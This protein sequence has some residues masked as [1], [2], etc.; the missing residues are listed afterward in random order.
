MK[1]LVDIRD[2]KA[3]FVMELLNNF[4]FVKTKPISNE[5]ALLM[6]EIKEAVENVKRAKQGKLKAKPLNELAEILLRGESSLSRGERE[7]AGQF[8]FGDE[9][10]VAVG[11]LHASWSSRCD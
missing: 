1:V 8:V 3:A 6:E 5:K 7:I 11:G 2:N 9:G 4:P 10:A